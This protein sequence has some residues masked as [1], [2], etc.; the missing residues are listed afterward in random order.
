MD[1][2]AAQRVVD[3]LRR[4]IE[5]YERRLAD[6]NTSVAVREALTEAAAEDEREIQRI[7]DLFSAGREDDANS[8]SS[9]ESEVS[10]LGEMQTVEQRM[11]EM[12]AQRGWPADAQP[13]FQQD[14]E[15]DDVA[16]E[17]MTADVAQDS[18]DEDDRTQ[19]RQARLRAEDDEASQW[20]LPEAQRPFPTISRRGRRTQLPTVSRSRG[21]AVA[22]PTQRALL[23]RTRPMPPRDPRTGRF[24]RRK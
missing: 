9:S 20:W 19:Y 3:G 10:D 1:Q 11:Q 23:T 2:A 13:L 18:A 4:N 22:P 16:S 14:W 24:I 17:A 12:R 7:K 6:P 5:G 21:L 15:D 8:D